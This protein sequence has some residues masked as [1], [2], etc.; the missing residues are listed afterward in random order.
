VVDAW[1]HWE[2]YGKQ[3]GFGARKKF[4]NKSKLDGKV[5]TRGFAYC[6]EGVR[7]VEKGDN[8]YSRCQVEIKINCHAWLFV[9]LV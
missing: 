5:T 1:K 8:L 9:S 6:E 4:M 3:I 2:N 7:G